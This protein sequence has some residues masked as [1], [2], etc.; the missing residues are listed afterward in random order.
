MAANDT[1]GTNIDSKALSNLDALKKKMAEIGSEEMKN[2]TKLEKW[3]AGVGAI[4]V[5]TKDVQ[6]AEELISES[7]RDIEDH[8][9]KIRILDESIATYV[10]SQVRSGKQ[11]NVAMAEGE[12]IARATAKQMGLQW[13]DTQDMLLAAKAKKGIENEESTLLGRMEKTTGKISQYFKDAEVGSRVV[14]NS[15]TGHLEMRQTLGDKAKGGLA[16]SFE[17]LKGGLMPDILAGGLVM[18]LI[19]MMNMGMVL[20]AEARQFST[21]IGDIN[22]KGRDGVNAATSLGN[23][24]HMTST[25][26]MKFMQ[27]LAASGAV[28]TSMNETTGDIANRVER[29]KALEAVTTISMEQQLKTVVYLQQSFGAID[30]AMSGVGTRADDVNLKLV[31]M[32][33]DLKGAGIGVNEIYSSFSALIDSADELGISYKNAFMVYAALV[34]EKEKDGKQS[35]MI[36]QLNQKN[37]V[38][39]AETANRMTEMSLSSKAVIA[40]LA[41]K[42]ITGGL[43]GLETMFRGGSGGTDIGLKNL[44]MLTDAMHNLGRMVTGG[45]EFNLKDMYNTKTGQLTGFGGMMQQLVAGTGLM[46]QEVVNNSHLFAALMS[47]NSANLTPAL[48]KEYNTLTKE[49]KEMQNPQKTLIDKGTQ[50]IIELQGIE[51]Y[52]KWFENWMVKIGGWIESKIGGT[53]EQET[54]N[55][56]KL[57]YTRQ[58]I[59][60]M[61]EDEIHQILAL[62][63]TKLAWMTD[64]NFKGL[65]AKGAKLP[66]NLPE[67]EK[68]LPQNAIDAMSKMKRASDKVAWEKAHIN[69]AITKAKAEPPATG[70]GQAT[71]AQSSR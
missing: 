46:P 29:I 31:N 22:I 27:E 26:A 42:Q 21:L 16:K 20:N 41:G 5:Q 49:W 71:Y 54:K 48:K 57:G 61:S 58:Q 34:R 7:T 37:L 62:N 39:L 63:K 45:R 64:P 13:K 67:G 17:S 23:K 40:T 1:K 9:V 6:E 52:L 24:L 36:T 30:K 50:T 2:L 65:E 15:L 18:A 60:G 55:M 51:G 44:E 25:E 12:V 3:S 38:T 35:A 8:K 69:F 10:Q 70:T 47:G 11:V 33:V 28:M 59:Y 56:Q 32:S 14:R 66:V 4:L 68:V 43:V 53:A 19:K